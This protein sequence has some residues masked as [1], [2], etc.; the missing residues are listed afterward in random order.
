MYIDATLT[1]PSIIQLH[2]Q[3]ETLILSFVHCNRI[4]GK[5]GLFFP[6]DSVTCNGQ[7]YPQEP[8]LLPSLL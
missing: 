6:Q 8:C 4:F 3:G 5:K 7:G 1:L 2:M